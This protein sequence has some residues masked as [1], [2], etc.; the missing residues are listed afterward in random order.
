MA[1]VSKIEEL[2]KRHK[3]VCEEYLKTFCENYDFTYDNDSWVANDCGTIA[4]VGD[5]FFDFNDVIKYCVDHN[6][7]NVSELFEWYD[8]C[9]DAGTLN[10]N[11][12]PNFRSWHKGAPRIDSK[13]I[14]RL[15]TMKQDLQKQID[16]LNIEEGIF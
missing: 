2:K 6:L 7:K 11:N 16:D 10:I 12:V 5:M 1:S 9:I 13:T 14:R 15:I 4:C 8:Y 3:E